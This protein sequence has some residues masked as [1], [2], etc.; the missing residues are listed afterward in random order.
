MFIDKKSGI[1]LEGSSEVMTLSGNE[2]N[3]IAL[4][5]LRAGEKISVPVKITQDPSYLYEGIGLLLLF[6]MGLVYCFKGRIFG[7]RKKE[8]TL[9]ELE[10]EKRNIFMTIHGFEKHAG[11]ELS[12]E[13][14]KL[15]EEYRQKT[16]RICIK[17]DNLK[18]KNNI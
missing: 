4:S 12:E 8:Y 14:Q 2:Y 13:Y 18:N 9:E 1:D 5:D 10:I 11:P 15:M 7:R 3:V 17:I 6:S 16:I